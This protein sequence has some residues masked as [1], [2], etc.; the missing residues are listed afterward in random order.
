MLSG[1]VSNSLGENLTPVC[2]MGDDGAFSTS[3]SPWRRRPGVLG[4]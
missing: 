2:R 1:K 4:T 3:Y